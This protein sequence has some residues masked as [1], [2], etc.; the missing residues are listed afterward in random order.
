V[1]RRATT[2]QVAQPLRPRDLSGVGTDRIAEILTLPPQPTAE[3]WLQD[4]RGEERQRVG[5]LAELRSIYS[6]D[7][8]WEIAAELPRNDL[9]ARVGN[10]AS[11]R[12]AHYPDWLLLLLDCAAAITG[13]GTRR[14]ACA[15]LH[16]LPTWQMFADDVDDFVPPGFTPLRDLTPSPKRLAAYTRPLASAAVSSTSARARPRNSGTSRRPAGH[17]PITSL[18]PEDHHFDYFVL[19]WRGLRKVR[20]KVEPIDSSDPW[21]GVGPRVIAAFEKASMEMA[22]GMGLLD[23]SRP[24]QFKRPDPR[25]YVGLDGVVFPMSHRRPSDACEE[26]LTGA[27][28]KKVYGSKF[29]FAST[30]VLNQFGS[31]LIL[32]MAHNGGKNSPDPDEGTASEEIANELAKLSRGGM[33]GIIIDSVIRGE[34]I[35]RLARNGITVVNYPH[36][37]RNPLAK[38]GVR[39]GDGRTDKSYLRDIATHHDHNGLPCEHL[40]YFVGGVLVQLKTGHDGTQLATEVRIVDHKRRGNAGARRDYFD[41]EIDCSVVGA[42]RH[43][44]PLFHREVSGNAPNVNFGEVARVFAPN[45]TNFAKLYGMRNDTESRHTNLKGSLTRFPGH[46]F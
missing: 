15:M 13:V 28:R 9:G 18:P 45:S 25:Q 10:R 3:R 36:A 37:Q 5:P 23:P 4:R 31:R 29:T 32:A 46:L 16:D 35:T 20:G 42:F 26:H 21:Y 34:R 27:D 43:L 14:S 8:F 41:A 2:R 12:P 38:E 7:Q 6:S 11:G 24:F 33:K 19:R 39:R 22:Q 1:T 17:K 40:L 44:V 30:R